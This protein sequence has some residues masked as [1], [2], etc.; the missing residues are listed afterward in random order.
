M[1]KL[2][3]QGFSFLIVSGTGWLM[4]LSIFTIL[5]SC[6]SLNVLYGNMI[7]GIPALTFVFMVSTRK[8]FSSR[9]GQ[10]SLKQ[11]YL[12]YFI[13]QMILM[14]TVSCLGQFLYDILI[15][16]EYMKQQWILQHLKFI[17]KIIITPITMTVN[18]CVMKFLSERI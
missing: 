2:L 17:I 5:T 7:S 11:K 18:F 12:V 13:Y 1:K 6:L 9:L 10:L 15:G 8:I 4:D 14:F 16:M 3:K